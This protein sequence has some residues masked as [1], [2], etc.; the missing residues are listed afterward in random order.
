MPVYDY[1]CVA[2]GEFTVLRPMAEY[3][4]PHPCPGCGA[5][6]PRVLLTV[7]ALA[8]MDG[9]R[10]IAMATN[11]RNSHAPRRAEKSHGSNCT[12][13]GGLNSGRTRHGK[14]GSKSFPSA[15]PWM[16]SH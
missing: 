5:F 13:C 10:R 15:R 6:A 12:C 14:D 8:M 16:V 11:E 7:P 9:A 1:S 3:D 4:Q 2:C